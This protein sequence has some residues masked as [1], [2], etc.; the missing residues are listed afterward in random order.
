MV[1][2]SG[3]QELGGPGSLNRLNPRFLRHWLALILTQTLNSIS[4]M[5]IVFVYSHNVCIFVDLFTEAIA[6]VF[7]GVLFNTVIVIIAIVKVANPVQVNRLSLPNYS[8]Q[9]DNNYISRS[10]R[11]NPRLYPGLVMPQA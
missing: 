9:P 6:V 8:R 7:L 10:P 1:H 3:A 2:Y 11:L 5:Y 4:C